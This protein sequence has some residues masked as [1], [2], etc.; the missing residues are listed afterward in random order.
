VSHALSPHHP[1]DMSPP[2]L[3]TTP[4][5]RIDAVS[6]L[7]RAGEASTRGLAGVSLEIHAG[8]YVAIW[9][10]PGA[11]N[12]PCSRFSVC[13]TLPHRVNTTWVAVLDVVVDGEVADQDARAPSGWVPG[14]APLVRYSLRTPRG[15]GAL[16]V[17]DRAAR[18]DEH[19][20]DA[21]HS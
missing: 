13:W 15:R 16:S 12:R 18:A 19:Q 9:V 7:F 20:C 10:R 8:E 5:V 17:T 14:P 3:V 1:P 11:G 21:A 2:D 4:L 6:R